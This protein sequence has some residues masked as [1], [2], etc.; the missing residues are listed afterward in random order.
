GFSGVWEEA[1]VAGARHFN[2]RAALL[3]APLIN[4]LGLAGYHL[5]G[6]QTCAGAADQGRELP[7]AGADLEHRFAPRQLQE[8]QRSV[9]PR[10]VHVLPVAVDRFDSG[11]PCRF[12]CERI[13]AVQRLDRFRRLRWWTPQK[14]GDAMAD[15]VSRAVGCDKGPT[16]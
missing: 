9:T 10:R 4:E 7:H 14:A 2:V 15:R 5:Q 3:P 1:I 13:D 12:P 16:F 8:L 6:V 11:I